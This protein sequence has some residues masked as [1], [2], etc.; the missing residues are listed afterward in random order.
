MKNLT[1]KIKTF[2]QQDP[3]GLIGSVLIYIFF[4]ILLFHII[5]IIY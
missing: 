1:E 5:P 3:Q 2:Y 4:Y